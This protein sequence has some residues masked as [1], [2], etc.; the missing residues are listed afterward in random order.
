MYVG[1]K[2][3]N[4]WQFVVNS[5]SWNNMSGGSITG[6]AINSMALDEAHG[7]VY[8]A[9]YPIGQVPGAKNLWVAPMSTTWTNML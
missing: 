2:S 9:T 3:G 1:T 5:N 8:A 6:Y 4:V 7:L